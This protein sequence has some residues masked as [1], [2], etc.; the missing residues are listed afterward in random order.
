MPCS[1]RFNSRTLPFFCWG[2][3][4]GRPESQ[5]TNQGPT[6]FRELQAEREP[7]SCKVWGLGFRVWD[8][9]MMTGT[10]GL[11]FGGLG[12]RLSGAPHIQDSTVWGVRSGFPLV[13][14]TI[15]DVK[16]G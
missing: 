1:T 7:Q 14:S 13:Y 9:I 12:F 2:G 6:L 16:S 11:S 5:C 3:G 10:C 15:L 8:S 4:G